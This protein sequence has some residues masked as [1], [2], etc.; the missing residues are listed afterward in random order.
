MRPLLRLGVAIALSAVPAACT[1]L[2]DTGGLTG[3]ANDAGGVEAASTDAPPPPPEPPP[4]P[5][6]DAGDAGEDGGGR[7]TS[8][9]L[10]LYTF[11]EGSGQVVHDLSGVVPALDLQ[12]QTDPDGGKAAFVDGGFQITSSA[13][14]ASSSPATKIIAA[15]QAGGAVTVETWV[16][17]A[18][19]TQTLARIAGVSGGNSQHDIGLD[20]DGTDY[21]ALMNTSTGLAELYS[22]TNTV[23]TR[24][25]HVVVTRA[26]DAT[27]RIFVDG[28]ES[29]TDNQPD[30][31]A[32]SWN[33][34][35]G[36]TCGNATDFS[37]P[38]VGTYH[39]VAFYDHAL[40]PAEIAQN[41][42]AGP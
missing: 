23:A 10:A 22:S 20:Q 18:N 6:T 30:A 14:A 40:T 15:F 4:P 34:T 38:W 37:A 24:R 41:F 1:L 19:T 28:L 5:S 16:T 35:F 9:L 7:V 25:Q 42:A 21:Y 12:I 39:L 31:G 3:G 8:G 13:L 11:R 29:G 32:S 17:P 27:R 2:V 36:V 33:T 26:P